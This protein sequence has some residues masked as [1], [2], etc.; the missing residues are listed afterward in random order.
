MEQDL[1]RFRDLVEDLQAVAWEADPSTGTYSFVSDCVLDLTGIP[2]ERWAAEPHLWEE[3]IHP[4]DRAEVR[5]QRRRMLDESKGGTLEYRFLTE[6]GTCLWLLDIVRVVKDDEGNAGFFRGLT[7]DVSDR[8]ATEEATRLERDSGLRLLAERLPIILWTT[9]KRLRLTSAYGAGLAEFNL[10]A[11]QVKGM[12]LF[13]YFNADDPEFTPIAS[14][15]Q[16]LRGE[17]LSYERELM[18]RTYH[19][20]VEPLQ[21]GGGEVLGTIGA[22]L[23]I[24][25]RKKAEEELRRSMDLLKIADEG[26]ARLLSHLVR[27][28]EEERKTIAAGI[29]DDTIQVMG[30]LKLHLG[31]LRRSLAAPEEVASLQRLEDEVHLA[32]DRL[33]H[34]LF[35]LR[36]PSL[37]RDGLASA[38]QIV[39]EQTRR[40]DGIEYSLVNN[41]PSEPADD[42]RI[43]V[44]RVAFEAISNIRKHA[45]ATVINVMLEESDGGV[46]VRVQDD[47]KG[48]EEGALEPEPGHLGLIGMRERAEL[49]GGRF[50]IESRPGEGTVVECWIPPARSLAALPQEQLESGRTG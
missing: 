49:A 21:N 47:G 11:D 42:A 38:L 3:H 35:D 50:L 29:H 40:E 24:T 45:E 15:H 31:M 9:D 5:E 23:D 13:E 2:A 18:G 1:S 34:L 30:A 25:D 16:A 37:D 19:F 4:L 22:A 41:L 39:L 12:S 26:R 33:R 28:Q 20:H 36:P 48:F 8:K 14:H 27:A 43:I 32:I 46:L 10:D 44:Y 17:P 6:E 7:V